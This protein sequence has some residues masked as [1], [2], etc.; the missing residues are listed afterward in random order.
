[1][2]E[3]SAVQCHAGQCS[4]M[5]C[6][7]VPCSALQCHGMQY[8]AMQCSTVQC[9]AVQCHAVQ[10]SAMQCSAVVECSGIGAIIRTLSK[11]WMVSCIVYLVFDQ[12]WWRHKNPCVKYWMDLV[13]SVKKKSQKKNPP[14]FFVNIFISLKIFVL[15]T[16][17]NK[18]QCYMYLEHNKNLCY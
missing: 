10:Y 7:T 5:Q 16:N 9:S 14:I 11:D 3:C 2:L 18:N 4:A 12:S 13:L 1:M 15:A 17:S 6:S 8:S